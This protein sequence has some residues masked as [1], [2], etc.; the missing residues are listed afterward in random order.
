MAEKAKKVHH[1]FY[2]ISALRWTFKLIQTVFNYKQCVLGCKKALFCHCVLPLRNAGC[3]NVYT[4][5]CI[6]ATCITSLDS[7]GFESRDIMTVSGHRSE[8]S[9]KHYSKTSDS[10]KREMSLQ[11]TANLYHSSNSK[12]KAS[13]STTISESVS[14]VKHSKHRPVHTPFA[15]GNDTT[16]CSTRSSSASTT[17]SAS[18]K[19]ILINK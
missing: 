15:P 13:S 14:N 8:S 7:A 1:T 10:W 12:S 19:P 4:N 11:M 5:H 9:L 2:N 17:I 3:T 16:A 6:R 18:E